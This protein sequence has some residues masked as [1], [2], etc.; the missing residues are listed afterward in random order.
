MISRI[1]LS[2]M[3]EGK[4]NTTNEHDTYDLDDKKGDIQHREHYEL[5]EHPHHSS[6]HRGGRGARNTAP[7]P[8]DLGVGASGSDQ[9]RTRI[10]HISVVAG[11]PAT[12]SIYMTSSRDIESTAEGAGTR[13][14]LPRIDS[15]RVLETSGWYSSDDGQ[16]LE[17]D[18]TIATVPDTATV[19]QSIGVISISP[20]RTEEA[21][22]Y[23]NRSELTIGSRQGLSLSSPGPSI[24]RDPRGKRRAT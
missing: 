16:I 2:L 12:R 8:A 23:G 24:T 4:R 7:M 13:T 17:D 14:A 22:R 10:P 15:G 11:T 9:S 6:A 19:S 21:L 20:R 18:T 3:R 1:T 5:R